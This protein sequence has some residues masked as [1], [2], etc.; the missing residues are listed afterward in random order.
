MVLSGMS[1]GSQS[2]KVWS[3]RSSEGRGVAG[4]RAEKA[5][6]RAERPRAKEPRAAMPRGMVPGAEKLR[7][8]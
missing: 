6:A 1:G 4:L 2:S 7:V 5:S 3:M 8:E